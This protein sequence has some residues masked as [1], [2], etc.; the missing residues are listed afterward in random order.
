VIKLRA[1]DVFPW[2]TVKP[3]LAPKERARTWGTTLER[4]T[5]LRSGSQ[6]CCSE[7][8]PCGAAKAAPFK[9]CGLHKQILESGAQGSSRF[10]HCEFRG[11][12]AVNGG[13]L[14]FFQHG[15]DSFQDDADCHGSHGF[16]GL[17]HGG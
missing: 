15:V 13:D 10:P 4:A 7:C 1:G 16:H 12:L 17:A 8:L 14:P 11:Q 6:T 2:S 3:R 5:R 9:A